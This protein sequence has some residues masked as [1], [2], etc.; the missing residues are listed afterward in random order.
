MRIIQ[1]IER[2]PIPKEQSN[3]KLDIDDLMAIE[4]AEKECFVQMLKLFA[5]ENNLQKV[6]PKTDIRESTLKQFMAKNSEF[7][8]KRKCNIQQRFPI[9]KIPETLLFTHK[10]DTCCQAMCQE[11]KTAKNPAFRQRR[12]LNRLDSVTVCTIGVN[13]NAG[14]ADSRVFILCYCHRIVFWCMIEKEG[15]ILSTGQEKMDT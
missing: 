8:E 7:K 3:K 4:R 11:H 14:I 1:Y 13:S 12:I 6:E 10:L 2:I 5:K 9:K 15:M